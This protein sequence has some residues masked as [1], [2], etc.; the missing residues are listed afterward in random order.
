MAFPKVRNHGRITPSHEY[1]RRRRI[2]SAKISLAISVGVVLIAAVLGVEAVP[3]QDT[4][5]S[6]LGD[7]LKTQYKL[8]KMGSDSSALFL[9]EHGTILVIK[10]TPIPPY[11]PPPPT[12]LPNTHS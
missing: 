5:A 1:S 9:T 4:A 10:N 2:M 7:Q 3:T 11:P 12:V 6:S 8:A